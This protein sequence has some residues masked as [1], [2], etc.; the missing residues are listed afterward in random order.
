MNDLTRLI[1][2]E[3][4]LEEI[5]ESDMEADWEVCLTLIE[6]RH[7]LHEQVMADETLNEDEVRQ[8]LAQSLVNNRKLLAAAQN[9]KPEIEKR[10]IKLAQSKRAH[11]LYE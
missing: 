4:K 5:L 8:A 9:D 3:C 2:L 10:L 6:K 11:K 7:N 1:E